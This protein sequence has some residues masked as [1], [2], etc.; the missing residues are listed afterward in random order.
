VTPR[1]HEILERV[2]HAPA[3]RAFAVVLASEGLDGALHACR[4]RRVSAAVATRLAAGSWT[5]ERHL[6]PVEFVADLVLAA[7][8]LA[9]G[10]LSHQLDVRAA[11]DELQL[12]LSEARKALQ[13]Y[14][15]YAA[16]AP[17]LPQELQDMLPR[18]P[19]IPKAVM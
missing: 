8:L 10:P 1:E 14:A 9:T 18:V 6:P 11:A 13:T 17:A 3:L 5:A 4:V 16:S 19:R 7:R 2:L 12:P 15:R